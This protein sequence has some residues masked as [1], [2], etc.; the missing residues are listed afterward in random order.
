[1]SILAH[2][3]NASSAFCPP[4]TSAVRSRSGQP[5]SVSNRLGSEDLQAA[6]RAA[7]ALR[8]SGLGAFDNSS[9]VA[10]QEALDAWG[11]GL[12]GLRGDPGVCGCGFL[13]WEPGNW[14]ACS[15][16]PGGWIL[17]HAQVGTRDGLLI[18]QFGSH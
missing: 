8:Q 14:K 13:K 5:V 17:T 4:P 12:R 3:S 18:G 1:M 7:A 6:Y 9:V 11:P 15:P 2:V 16:Y 10:A